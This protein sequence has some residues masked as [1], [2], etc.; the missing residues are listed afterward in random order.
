MAFVNKKN[1]N[2]I[3]E[4]RGDRFMQMITTFFLLLI[5]VVVGYPVIY[6]V[7]CSFSS[8]AALTTGKVLLWPVEPTLAGYK[9]VLKFERI[10]LGYR[11]TI[12]YTVFGVII[13]MVLQ[14]LC[15]YPLSRSSY[16]GRGPL[17]K[18]IYFTTL[19]HAGLVP[20]YIIYSN[21]G[22]VNTVWSI[23]LAYTISVSRVIIMRTA[24]KSVPSE[25]YD[26]A[27]ID[28]ATPFQTMAQIVLPLVK[29]TISTLTLYTAVGCWNDYFT[30]M[31]YLRNDQLYPLQLFLRT[32]LTTAQSLTADAL[33]SSGSMMGPTQEGVN[34][35][36]FCIII[37]A[38]VPV[39]LLYFGVQSSFKKGVMIGSVKG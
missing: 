22:L 39:L 4:T 12:F 33:H 35:I 17:M 18:I 15:A 19:F 26:S 25:L 1:T 31:I 14:V 37:M 11:N 7:S 5:L 23:L 29:A 36:E 32:I 8:D 30:A 34:Q 38:T 3:I 10:W 13:A 27:A 20:T 2:K 21:L 28:G 9:F 16:Q 24:F 6:V